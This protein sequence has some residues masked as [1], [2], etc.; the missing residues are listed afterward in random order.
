MKKMLR[1]VPGSF[2][3]RV[4]F[5]MMVLMWG[6]Q[7]Q[8]RDIAYVPH[9]R[10]AQ[11]YSPHITP[12]GRIFNAQGLVSGQVSTDGKVMDRHDLPVGEVKPADPSKPL[13]AT[14]RARV[15]DT[16]GYELAYMNSKGLVSNERRERLGFVDKSGRVT[17]RHGYPVGYVPSDMRADGMLFLLRGHGLDLP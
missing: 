6:S 17:D 2:A 1:G 7:L 13:S 4:G 5:G 12:D 3:L 15:L 14:N 10:A 11:S 16:S 8:A 9:A